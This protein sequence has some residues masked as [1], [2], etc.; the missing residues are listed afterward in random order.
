MGIA[1]RTASPETTFT[2]LVGDLKSA[3]S[4]L[5][6]YLHACV[7]IRTYSCT[8]PSLYCHTC[9]LVCFRF[10]KH[11]LG[12]DLTRVTM[13]VHFNEPLSFTQRI[14]EDMEYSDLLHN[15]AGMYICMYLRMHVT[16]CR[17]INT[18]IRTYVCKCDQS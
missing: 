13:P 3:R 9:S 11:F 18:Y 4:C 6:S 12:R 17:Y 15:A 14:V 1:F 16:V 5:Y 7:Q 10:L 2:D 8:F